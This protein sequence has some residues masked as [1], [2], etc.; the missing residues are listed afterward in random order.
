M[1]TLQSKG[2]YKLADNVLDE[3]RCGGRQGLPVLKNIPPVAFIVKYWVITFVLC[4]NVKMVPWSTGVTM[5]SS[6]GQRKIF[7][8]N[9]SKAG[10]I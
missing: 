4:N 10:V 3:S 6:K 1:S 7:S 9:S 8:A 2:A 5:S